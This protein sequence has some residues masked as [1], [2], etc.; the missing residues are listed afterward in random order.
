MTEQEIFNA[1]PVGEANALTRHELAELFG[2]SERELRAV[3][4]R[5]RRS[6]AIICACGK[7]YF[8]PAV[9]R[10]VEA[11]IMREERQAANVPE[12]I[13]AAKRA[14]RSGVRS[15]DTR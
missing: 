9:R 4:D 1:L 3:I 11:Y 6:G 13:K 14:A 5:L 8:R 7:G 2:L 10:E 15:S 12:S